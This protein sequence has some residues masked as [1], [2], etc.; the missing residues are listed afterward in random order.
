MRY[1]IFS[2]LLL[3]CCVVDLSA[4]SILDWQSYT[5][6]RSVS[7]ITEDSKGRIWMTTEG[8]V[9]VTE[10]SKVIK[11]LTPIEELAR[12]D[13]S[14]IIYS[15]ELKKIFIG[16]LTGEIDVV[17]ENDFQV[18]K[19]TDIKRN[20]SFSQKAINDF[21]LLENSLFVATD[22]G[23]VEYNLNGLFVKDTY[24]KFGNFNTAIPVNTILE[25]SGV[26]YLGTEEGIA[27]TIQD[28]SFSSSDWENYTDS[29][30]YTSESTEAL[31]F[32]DNELYASTLVENYKLTDGTWGINS[33]FGNAVI[34]DYKTTNNFIIALSEEMIYHKEGTQNFHSSSL[35]GSIG[36]VISREPFTDTILVGTRIN[37]LGILDLSNDTISYE[38]QEGPYVNFFEGLNFYDGVLIS[39]ST[40]SSSRREEIDKT[41]GFYIFENGEWEN[42]NE[43]ITPDF[44]N[45]VYRQPF[46]TTASENYY[47]FGSWGTG[48]VR[49]DKETD[50]IKLF[51]ETNSTLRGWPQDNELYPV[52][53]GLET[54][55]NNDVWLVSRY[56]NTPLYRQTP[57]D[58]D[59]QQFQENSAVS[60]SD[61]YENLFIDSF[62]QKWIALQ[63]AQSSG[64]G[65]LVIDTKNPEDES[66][67]VGV[68]LQSGTNSGNLPDSKV[69]VIVEDKNGE[70]W[71]GTSRGIAKFIFPEL[72][73]EGSIQ[74]R[75]AQWLINEDTS[76]VSRFLLRDVNATAMAVN[77]ANEKWIGS[78]NQG[79][80]LLNAEGSKILKRF[81]MDNSPLFS[82]S[83]KSIAINDVTGEVF[84]GTDVGLISYQGIPNKSVSKMEELKVFP[85]PFSYKKN[86]LVF[87]EGLSDKTIVK[88]L[89]VDGMVVNSF[90]TNGGRVSWDGRDSTG[91]MLGSGVYFV[92]AVDSEGNS[93]GVGKVVIVR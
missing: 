18:E 71:I 4:Q 37:G 12:L 32:F 86:D 91:G 22:F 92:V 1:T 11:T 47:Y 27:F 81:T 34:V 74:E 75:T 78:A 63:N 79:I 51:D 43:I 84:I 67:D 5:S 26:L 76:A 55:S 15:E 16:Y 44:Q 88:V 33:E 17:D 46:K 3:F 48:V 8:G 65:L 58:D 20:N 83:I 41:R 6:F 73:V 77:A 61:L 40:R 31:G 62:D 9:L 80:Y 13:G 66:D 85:N 28:G 52:I 72:I 30:G 64:T 45:V 69:N 14:T 82:N 19:L 29:D 35:Q 56:G 36:T 10:N 90:T 49:F 2:V 70:V 59:W 50:E 21:Y 39:G 42:Y 25:D 93:K 53:S 89:G 24:T 68:K 54:D 57:G 23:L 87:I 60:S 7:D 38:T